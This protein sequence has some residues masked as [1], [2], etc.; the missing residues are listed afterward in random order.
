MRSKTKNFSFTNQTHGKHNEQVDQS[1][2][3]LRLKRAV[4]ITV[5]SLSLPI[6]ALLSTWI[7]LWIKVVSPGNALFQQTRIGRN[8]NTF[9]LYKFRSMKPCANT[10][11]HES[12]IQHLAKSNLPMTKLDF[13]GDTRLIRGGCLIRMLGLDELPQFI[14]ILLGEM[15]LVGP[16]PCLPSELDLYDINQR[17]RFTVRPG[18]TGQWQ[19]DRNA[20]TTFAQMVQMDEEYVKN[21]SITKDFKIIL[22]TPIAL[23]AQM[24]TNLK[25]QS[26]QILQRKQ[27]RP[28]SPRQ[29]NQE[30][31]SASEMA[32]LPNA[33]AKT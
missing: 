14:N 28:P 13:S 23:I 26:L 27:H 8:Q 10:S 21:Q 15:S 3:T 2:F 18:I 5:V 20:C 11:I 16:R 33:L 31:R 30:D 1:T 29:S 9:T 17:Q 6:V 24:A 19:V 12:H 22:K 25:S 4:D 32:K 7:Y